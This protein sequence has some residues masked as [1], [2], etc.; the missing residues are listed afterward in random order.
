MSG[1]DNIKMLWIAYLAVHDSEGYSIYDMAYY[2]CPVYDNLMS[3]Y[4]FL[5]FICHQKVRIWE[6]IFKIW[7]YNPQNTTLLFLYMTAQK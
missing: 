1:Y 6:H 7:N 2:P 4:V 5:I 3:V